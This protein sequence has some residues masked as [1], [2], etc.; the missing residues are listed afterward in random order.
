MPKWEI[1]IE[2]RRNFASLPIICDPSHMAGDASLV[3]ELSQKALDL[4]MDGLMIEVHNDPASALSDCNQQLTPAE[5]NNLMTKLMVRKLKS[6]DPGFY[7]Y[8]EELRD[9]VDS[10]DH[11][12][13][14]LLARRFELSDLIGDYKSRNNVAILQM[15]R[16]LEI[17]KT[18][19][20][21]ARLAGMD[22]NFTE[23]LLKLLHQE[24]IRRQTSV[25]DELKRNGEISV[26]DGPGN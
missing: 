16:W 1:P 10:V 26:D 14:E 7:N 22:H 11:Q 2:L 24:S 20:E 13:I 12:M 17:L 23:K 15:E 8:L 4:N 18:R 21:Q 25:M 3:P 5:Y 19:V 6:D 9:Q